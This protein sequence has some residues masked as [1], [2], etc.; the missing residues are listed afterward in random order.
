MAGQPLANLP[1]WLKLGAAVASGYSSAMAVPLPAQ[2][3]HQRTVT[4][5]ARVN[6]ACEDPSLPVTGL[7]P[8]AYAVEALGAAA[9]AVRRF[10]AS[11]CPS[12]GGS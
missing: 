6:L 10:S 3:L 9:V 4:V 8:L 7:T 5:H 1:L 11:H 2:W 12:R